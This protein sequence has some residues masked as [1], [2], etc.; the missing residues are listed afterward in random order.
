M[1]QL[2]GVIVALLAAVGGCSSSTDT[3]ALEPGQY[4]VVESEGACGPD[5]VVVDGDGR[6]MLSGCE[7]TRPVDDGCGWVCSGEGIKATL[8]YAGSDE[9]TGAVRDG[10]C[11]YEAT[12]QRSR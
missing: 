5:G 9:M 4:T 11:S 6:A 1:R 12:W 3:C 10:A 2:L 7:E 8:R